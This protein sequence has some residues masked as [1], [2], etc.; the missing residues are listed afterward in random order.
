MEEMHRILKFTSLESSTFEKGFLCLLGV[1]F[2]LL[3]FFDSKR[4]EDYSASQIC[5][6]SLI[7][8]KI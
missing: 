4:F 7:L 2:A 8:M 1:I 3:K 6:L 5:N